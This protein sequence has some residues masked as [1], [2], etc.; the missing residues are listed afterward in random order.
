MGP[1]RPQSRSSARIRLLTTLPQRCH[2][3]KGASS[4]SPAKI[5]FEKLFF[6]VKLVLPSAAFIT[7]ADW[8]F[9]S[10]KIQENF[11]HIEDHE[12]F[13][14]N[15]YT[16]SIPKVRLFLSRNAVGRDFWVRFSLFWCHL[17][18]PLAFSFS[19]FLPFIINKSHL[20]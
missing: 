2:E 5:K 9:S 14:M 4:F 7:T 15:I 6:D 10:A 8:I 19:F 20:F 13:S 3:F 11:G 16:I 18:Q 17:H 12:V 1:L